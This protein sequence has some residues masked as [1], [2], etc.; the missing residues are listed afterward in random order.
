MSRIIYRRRLWIAVLTAA[1][2]IGVIGIPWPATAAPPDALTIAIT[3][4][5]FAY[6]PESIRVPRGARLTLTLE[7]LDTVHGLSLDGHA[8]EM[9]A[10]PGRSSRATFVA[11]HEGKFKFRCSV[12]CGALHPFMIGEVVVEPEVP[13]A[14]VTLATLVI[15]GSALA[16]FWKR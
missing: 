12:S 1:L 9:T 11:E 6:A 14:R 2:L 7:S 8:V 10:E 3:A 5:A 4:R 16:W 15:S 13:F